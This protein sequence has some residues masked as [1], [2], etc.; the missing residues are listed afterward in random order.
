M[1]D[2]KLPKKMESGIR[3]YGDG[4]G[5]R[6]EVTKGRNPIT[7]KKNRK[8]AVVY[9]SYKKAV[10][11]KHELLAVLGD[12]ASL[13]AN[14]TLSDFW[15]NWYL[16]DCEQR[17]RPVTVHGYVSHY[18]QFIQ[19]QLDE[20]KLADI[21]PLVIR[22]WLEGISGEKRR[23]EAFKL[24]RQ[25]CTKAVRWDVL[26]D[27][28][29]S[30]VDRPS[31]PQDYEPEVLSTEEVPAY[32]DTFRGTPLEACVTLCIAC[33]FRRSEVI[34]LDWEDIRDGA[35][36]VTHAV[37]S[38]AGKAWDDDPKSRFGNRTV[39][40][41]SVFLDRLEQ[42]RSTG[43]IVKD[44]DG[45]RMNPDNVSKLYGK[46][47]RK[48]PDGVTRVPLKNLRHTSLSLFYE[49]TGDLLATS[50]RG[51]HSSMSVTSRYYVRPSRSVDKAG[52]EAFGEMID[53]AT[54]AP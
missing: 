3:P 41:P 31:K 48:L 5:W 38:V 6:V 49:A 40:V 10:E 32:L 24:L 28:P 15:S 35:I 50:R 14:I 45:N 54:K 34:A 4:D 12:T 47:Q 19:G 36:D 26:G 16:P 17:L 22:K 43:P 33:G 39:A 25:I 29:C 1:A 30:H 7:G 18:R 27:N 23:F 52:A 44:T 13:K 51:G 21:T 2:R 42:I 46:I 37:T 53:N 8:S 9:G 11:K 20:L